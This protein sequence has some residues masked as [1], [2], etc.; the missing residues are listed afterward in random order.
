MHRL[1]DYT[2]PHIHFKGHTSPCKYRWPHASWSWLSSYS[3]A[4]LC[5][6]FSSHFP[7]DYALWV[8]FIW[9]IEYFVQP[10]SLNNICFLWVRVTKICCSMHRTNRKNN[11]SHYSSPNT[12]LY[13]FPQSGKLK[14]SKGSLCQYLLCRK[15]V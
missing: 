14:D 1:S 15:E 3:T 9:L 2:Q 4:H 8:C 5:L 11:Y 7:P 6:S 10:K 13:F 12:F